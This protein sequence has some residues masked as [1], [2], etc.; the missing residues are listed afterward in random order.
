MFVAFRT[1]LMASS[2]LFTSAFGFRERTTD[3]L[4]KGT[5]YRFTVPWASSSTCFSMPP[6]NSSAMCTPCFAR[7]VLPKDI[8]VAES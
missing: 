3:G 6:L 4:K 8:L 2:A 7:R 1:S 5:M